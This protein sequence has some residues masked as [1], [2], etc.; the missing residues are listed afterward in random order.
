MSLVLSNAALAPFR[1]RG[2]RFQWPADLCV[3][4][5]F[6]MET[7][8]LG[9]YVLVESKS[10]FMLT[11]YASMAYVGTLLGPMLGVV[12]DRV[13]QRRLLACMRAFYGMLAGTIATLAFTGWLSPY[14]VLCTGALMGLVRPSDVGMRTALTAEI[15]PKVHLMS[16]MSIQRTTQDTARIAGALSGAGLVAALGM[17]PAY[18]VVFCL[19]VTSCLLVMRTG[20]AEPADA[21]A[22]TARQSPWRD[23]KEGL[24]YVTRTPFVLGTLVLAL[25]LNMTA[26]P[27]AISL[28]PYVVKEIYGGNQTLLGYV[29][30]CAGAGAVC[31]SLVITR[32]SGVLGPSRLM[33]VANICWFLLLLVFAQLQTATSGMITLFFSGI[34]Q[35]IGLVSM[36]TVL[37]RGSDEKFRGR[38]MGVRMLAI[39]S[40]MP[41][42]MLAGFLIPR[43]GYP[44]VAT[45]YCV[46][47]ILATLA[48]VW[49]WRAA[50]WSQDAASNAAQ[51]TDAR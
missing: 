48:I 34:A 25:L 10:V 30:T 51:A 40:N 24:S 29:V 39:Y 1:V 50:L 11:I 26:F 44:A 3:S 43:H 9:W 27:L 15:V 23:L 45:A 46:F 18:T 7:L 4:W 20:A 33:I 17:G 42:I 5:A 16:A 37:L 41:G 31:G 8:I 21:P 12:G 38:I 22:R 14:V 47:G 49:Y 13:G 35:A 28:L 19:Y 36:A 2:F 32:A 6:E